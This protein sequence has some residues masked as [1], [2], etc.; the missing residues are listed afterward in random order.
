[1]LKSK[2]LTRGRGLW[3][4]RELVDKSA[5][6]AACVSVAEA[7]VTAGP[8][9]QQVGGP[10]VKAQD[11]EAVE[12]AVGQRA[13]HYHLSGEAVRSVTLCASCHGAWHSG[14]HLQNF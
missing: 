8:P 9:D 2:G 10:D 4:P 14:K 11:L 6:A 5:W 12:R 7:K 3:Q 1:M 13:P